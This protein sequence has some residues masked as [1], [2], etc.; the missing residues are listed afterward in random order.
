MATR[1]TVMTWNVENLFPPGHMVSPGK[2]V[3]EADYRAKLKY[4]TKRILEVKP[5]VIGL[6][7]VGARS[8]ADSQTLDD[9]QN[10]LDGK[11]PFKA[12]AS[13]TDG[14]GIRV[15]FLS[16]LP[17]HSTA[18]ILEFPKGEFE[19]IQDWAGKKPIKKMGRIALQ[20]EV[21]PVA[22]M[23][24]HVIALHLKSKLVNYPKAGGGTSFSPKDENQRATGSGLGLLRRTA[25]AVAVRFHLNQLMKTA[26]NVIVLG[27][28][29]DE[30]QAATSQIF[31]GP[32]DADVTT[33]NKAD[34][35][36]LYNLVDKVSRKG[37]PE[38]DK[39]FL[40]A[41]ER[42]SRVGQSGNELLDHILASKS[43]LGASKDLKKDIWKVKS[44]RILT[45]SIVNET[46][47]LNPDERIGRDHPDHAPVFV[48]F[49]L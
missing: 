42:F 28:F 16:R 5:H 48:R 44:V 43:L 10:Q 35:F 3:K 24:V 6:Q 38:N 11:Y 23:R 15:G 8:N 47:G 49:A 22:G 19:R 30:P 25:E 31:L 2:T 9:L 39:K 7:E 27:D 33:D 17:I 26:P 46:V 32:V 34:K 12:L 37:G 20:I 29:N 40:K 18:E 14:R 45:D 41:K 13:K 21:E 4:L 36:G 1:F